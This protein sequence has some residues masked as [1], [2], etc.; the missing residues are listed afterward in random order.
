MLLSSR[1]AAEKIAAGRRLAIAG[2]EALL[3]RLPKGDWVG[4]TIP[5]FM[6]EDG[7]RV[8]KDLVF[9]H[10]LTEHTLGATIKSYDVADLPK[11]NV[12]APEHGFALV[13][14]P[15]NTRAHLSYAQDAPN[16]PGFFMKPIVGWISGV[17]MDDMGR[18]SPKVFDGSTG[19]SLRE[20][21]VVMHLP[22][23]A[24]KN[25]IIKILNLFRQGE[26]DTISFPGD[27][28]DFKTCL[29]NGVERGFAEYL[30]E[31]RVDI[32]LPLVANYCGV[33]VNSSFW[34]IR[35]DDGTV[36]LTTPVI[37]GVEYK[38]SAP[39]GDYIDDFNKALPKD[40]SP[41][42][43]CN[44]YLNFLYAGL[45]GRVVEKMAGP[46]TFGEIAYQL[47]SQTLVYLEIG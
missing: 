38:I 21:A 10:D 6:A 45:E 34:G 32:R 8:T 35:E 44:C 13:I 18:V 9:I 43:A 1:E 12:D 39:V 28:F 3:A 31:N 41:V 30:K 20:K 19:E 7:G 37:R 46:I 47:L 42:F 24:G 29:V 16:Y 22:I 5:Y 4:G 27:G 26:G 33:M 11:I 15:A 17:H 40:A 14:I 2:D 36:N 25:A 23:D